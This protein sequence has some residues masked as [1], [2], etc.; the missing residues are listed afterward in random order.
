[1]QYDQAILDKLSE[2]IGRVQEG[3]ETFPR[4]DMIFLIEQINTL[5]KK[6]LEYDKSV[7]EQQNGSE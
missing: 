4:E 3:Q 2:I 7:I 5:S 1:M 6:I